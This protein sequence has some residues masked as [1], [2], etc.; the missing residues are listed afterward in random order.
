MNSPSMMQFLNHLKFSHN[1]KLS[2]ELL[3][4]HDEKG[5]RTLDNVAGHLQH[6]K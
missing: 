4:F 6:L 5:G 2:E 3:E 1:T